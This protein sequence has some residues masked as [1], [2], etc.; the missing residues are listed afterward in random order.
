V[1]S[2]LAQQDRDLKD[3]NDDTQAAQHW[4]TMWPNV[5]PDSV[6]WRMA[7]APAPMEKETTKKS[8][9]GHHM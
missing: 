9:H 5:W 6:E 1:K 7:P 8:R 2:K 3:C 4:L